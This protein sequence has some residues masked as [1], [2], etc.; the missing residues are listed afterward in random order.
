MAIDGA[1]ECA[2]PPCVFG[3]GQGADTDYSACAADECCAATDITENDL[4]CVPTTAPSC[5]QA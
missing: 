3:T 1:G 5:D 2:D 4:T